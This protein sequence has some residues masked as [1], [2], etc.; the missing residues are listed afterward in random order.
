MHIWTIIY[1]FL[2]TSVF[3][4]LCLWSVKDGWYPSEKVLMKHP[5]PADTFYTFNQ[6]LAY[7]T[8]LLTLA[9]TLPAWLVIFGGRKSWVWMATLIFIALG[10]PNN[11]LMG[12]PVLVFWVKDGNKKFYGY[13]N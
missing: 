10:I 9:A 11:L 1:F 7:V 8:G 4:F 5:D 2:G 12:I 3:L 13:P 6:T